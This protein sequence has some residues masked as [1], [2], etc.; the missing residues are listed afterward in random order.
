MRPEK[1]I[2]AERDLPESRLAARKSHLV[3]ELRD[4]SATTRRRKHR[5]VLILVPAV[6][7]V[8][9]ASGF[10]TYALTRE[11]THFE[12]VG[13]FERAS[14]NADVAVLSADGSLP[15]EICGEVWRTGAFGGVEGAIAPPLTACVLDTGAVGVFPGAGPGTCAELGLAELPASYI[16]KANGFAGLHDAIVARIGEPASGSTRG[17]PQCVGEYEALAIVRRELLIRN[18]GDWEVRVVGEPFSAA[19]PCA[20][21]SF[22]TAEKTVLLHAAGPRS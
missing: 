5:R 9:A 13:C 17:G 12:S 1:M 10:T 19:R 14:L 16:K 21:A 8:L 11:P 22:D 2:P 15:T 20:D 18:F 3:Q 6:L 4:W 7:V